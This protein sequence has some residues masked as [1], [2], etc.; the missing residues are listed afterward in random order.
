MNNIKL[1]LNNFKIKLHYIKQC[2]I[3]AKENKLLIQYY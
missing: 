3:I 2:C 1:I